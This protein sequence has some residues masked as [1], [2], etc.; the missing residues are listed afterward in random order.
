MGEISDQ[1]IDC[2]DSEILGLAW[3]NDILHVTLKDHEDVRKTLVLS[4]LKGL[5]VN[6]LMTYNIVGDNEMVPAHEASEDFWKLLLCDSPNPEFFNKDRERLLAHVKKDGYA[7]YF[8][9]SVGV[10]FAALCTRLEWKLLS[11]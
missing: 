1:Y 11:A 4:G 8:A 5:I 3:D 10:S 9:G 2:H 7:V 6:D